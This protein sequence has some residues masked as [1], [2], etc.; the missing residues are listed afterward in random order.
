MDVFIQL[1]FLGDICQPAAYS[2][3]GEGNYRLVLVRIEYESV[4][5]VSAPDWQYWG[6][7][8]KSPGSKNRISPNAI[9][10]A[11]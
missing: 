10:L 8:V 4:L 5:E 11:N 1:C 3:I 6:P 9:V 7:E 2:G